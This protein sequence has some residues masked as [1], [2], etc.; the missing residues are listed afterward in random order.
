MGA[1]RGF[2]RVFHAGEF[3]AQR[4]W[5]AMLHKNAVRALR[6]F[7]GSS[8]LLVP[9]CA[10]GGGGTISSPGNGGPTPAT[11]EEVLTWHNDTAHTGQY[12]TETILT[13]AKVVPAT[14]GKLFTYPVD[15]QVYAQPLIKSNV[16]IGGAA[17]NVIYAVTMHDSVYCF[18]ADS[19]AG[20]NAGPLW[21]VSFLNPP[22]VTSIPL[23]DYPGYTDIHTEIGIL[24]TPVID[25]TSATLYVVSKTKET[26]AVTPANPNGHVYRLHALDLSSGAEKFGGSVV[27]AGTAPGVG[28][29]SVG[30]VITWDPYLQNQRCA[31]L[32][33]NG[34]IYLGFS[35]YGDSNYADPNFYHGWILAYNAQTLAQVGIWNDS[36]NDPGGANLG[37]GGIWMNSSSPGFDGTSIYV[38]TGNGWFDTTGPVTDYGDS[39]VK[40]LLQGGGPGVASYLSVSD[41]FTPSNQASLSSSDLDLD[42]GGL[43]L[44]PDQPGTIPH[45]LI[46]CGKN[47]TVYLIDRDNMTKFNSGGDQVVQE[48]AAFPGMTS[49]PAYWNNTIYYKPST[50]DISITTTTPLSA[51]PLI[52]GTATTPTKINFT[53]SSQ[54]AHQWG[55][56]GSTPSISANGNAGGIVWV[57]EADFSFVAGHPVATAAILRAY[58]AT[59]LASELYNNTTNP[60]DAMGPAVK[61]TLPTVAH[62]KVYVGADA[63]APAAGIVGEISVFGLK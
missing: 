38:I 17:H 23:A 48:V 3:P 15:G 52:P 36:P 54:S 31:L 22:A 63:A 20:G 37:E 16:V 24:S 50:I 14:F 27:L 11:F 58:D 28:D 25:P 26:A 34:V 21:H 42:A 56:P 59:N 60:G 41:Y 6:L 40:L 51:F 57:I 49:T 19:N 8:I 7:L 53:A 18:D 12:L 1:G 44:L 47:G 43:L 29:G 46:C 62:G 13:P 39:A 5:I 35:S 32:L 30:G 4:G 61:F 9:A 33:A 10:G 2:D 45:L 55:W